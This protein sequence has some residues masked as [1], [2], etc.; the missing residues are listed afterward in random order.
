MKMK[1]ITLAILAVGFSLFLYA[2]APT[3]ASGQGKD[4]NA[5]G[6]QL[7]MEYCAS[8]HGTDGKGGGPVAASLKT[9]VTDLTKIPLQEG[10]FP[11]LKIKNIISGQYTVPPHGT[12]EM[13]VWSLYF[14][15]TRGRG[16]AEA[17]LVALTRYI[18][19]IQVKQ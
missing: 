7:Y 19:S 4:K 6:Q 1:A 13:P 5:R 11:A 10:K 2:A 12:R 16:V 9:A 17:N 3:A 14:S 15:H 18:E 8:C